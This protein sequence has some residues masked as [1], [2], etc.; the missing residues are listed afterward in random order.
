M[1]HILLYEK[2]AR[3]LGLLVPFLIR[4]KCGSH[5]TT[6]LQQINYTVTLTE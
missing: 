4:F 5:N 3:V 6:E 2:Q 1:G